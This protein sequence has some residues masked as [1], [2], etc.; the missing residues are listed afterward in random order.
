MPPPPRPPRPTGRYSVTEIGP[1]QVEADPSLPPPPPKKPSGISGSVFVQGPGGWSFKGS[2]VAF[3]VL[4]IVGLPVAAVAVLLWLLPGVMGL[5]EIRGLRSDLAGA[6]GEIAALRATSAELDGRVGKVSDR[7]SV[8]ERREAENT[9]L[10][11]ATINRSASALLRYQDGSLP[12][13]SFHTAPL[14]GQPRHQP[15]AA[16]KRPR[17][18]R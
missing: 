14:R 9:E 5:D 1:R 4:A 16:L 18:D 10:L 2:T 11:A 13:A 6:R 3:V 8:L 7:L 12:E 17:T 15:Q